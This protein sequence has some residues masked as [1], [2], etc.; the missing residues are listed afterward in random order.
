MDNGTPYP[1]PA[2]TSNATAQAAR[3]LTSFFTAK[4]LR[5]IEATHAHFSPEQTYY[6]DATLGWEFPSNEALRQVWEQYMP[7]WGEAARSYP[8]QVL[9]DTSGAA[10]VMTD[11]PELFGGEIRGIAIVDFV[12]EKI[13]RWVDYWDGRGFGTGAADHLRVPAEDFPASLGA[14][15]VQA[16]P[17]PVLGA[18]VE[19]LMPAIRSGD[20]GRLNELLAYDATLEDLA[21]RTRV[22]GRA[23]VVRYLQRAC[24]RL[25]YQ[26]AVVRHVAG[27][28]QGG[29]FEWTAEGEEVP[30][31]A[32]ALALDGDGRI[33]SL[34]LCWDGSL[35][36]DD[37][38]TALTT[39]AIE[40]RR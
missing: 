33:T 22:R 23:A 16:R 24:G 34:T 9:G 30:R 18:A 32:A 40:P 27:N 36:D 5:R 25:P 1:G 39:L 12:D 4:T 20:D 21:L 10:V 38:I 35:L 31:G 8:V 15:T 17:A 2:D 3:L 7:R 19:H 37:R 13:M 26:G 14:D 29:G 11:T 28:E 6:A